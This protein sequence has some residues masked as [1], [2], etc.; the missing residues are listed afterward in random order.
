[1]R[2]KVLTH[3]VLLSGMALG[4]LILAGMGLASGGPVQDRSPSGG[5]L[6]EAGSYRFEVFFYPTGVRVH[7]Q[8][9]GGTPMDVSKLA[10][11]A[12]FYHPNSPEPWFS[13]PL[14]AERAGP[15]QTS[16][17]LVLVMNL[18]P[19]PP[20][21]AKVAFMLT[22]VAGAS[23][24]GHVRFTVPFEPVLTPPAPRLP[25][26]EG[27][28]AASP[29]YT[30]GLGY[31]GYGYYDPAPTQAVRAPTASPR[32]TRDWT[33]GRDVPLAKPWTSPHWSFDY[34]QWMARNM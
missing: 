32:R 25:S 21:G 24:E 17:S 20:N 9:K 31:Y 33:T 15:G 30:Y 7:P 26:T 8:D 19:V 16:N 27:T 14:K 10:G 29:R 6:A 34:N 2:P 3:P 12:T 5:L 23:D 11:T 1:M 28:A 13:R 18:D 22:G 4:G